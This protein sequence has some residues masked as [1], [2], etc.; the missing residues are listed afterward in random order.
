MNDRE[1]LFQHYVA[2]VCRQIQTKVELL[3]DEIRV[4][5]FT[6]FLPN[7]HQIVPLAKITADSTQFLAWRHQ[8]VATEVESG[9]ELECEAPNHL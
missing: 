3:H 2:G 7:I 8:L 6:W 1:N 4:L 5:R 9:M